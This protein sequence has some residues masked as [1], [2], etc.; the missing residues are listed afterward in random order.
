MRK[1]F[2][3]FLTFAFILSCGGGGGG[4]SP[5]EEAYTATDNKTSTIDIKANNWLFLVYMDADNNL[6]DFAD[7]DLQEMQQVKFPQ[8]V[9]VVVLVD[10]LG[11][12]SG[13]IYETDESGNL[14]LAESVSEPNMGD[15]QTLTDFVLKY[16]KQY[17]DHKKVL[18]F[19]NHGDGWRS[20]SL[21]SQLKMAAYDDTTKDALYMYEVKKALEDIT[22]AENFK[23]EVVGFD[24]CL[25]G[26]LEVFY[27]IANYTNYIV[28]SEQ[29]E[30]GAGWNYTAVFQNF[31]QNLSYYGDGFAFTKA[32]VDAYKDYGNQYDMDLTMLS[33]DSQSVKYL[34]E[35]VNK[36]AQRYLEDPTLKYEFQ[37]V[38]ESLP[39]ITYEGTD[40]QLVDLYNLAVQLNDTL[41]GN[42]TQ[43][44]IST[45][46]GLYRYTNNQDFQGISIYFPESADKADSNY[47]CSYY[48]PCEGGYYNPFT[49]TLWDEF[50]KAYLY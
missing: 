41:N 44:I 43:E 25:M 15:P 37:T 33:I 21:P 17:P 13:L 35:G 47:F 22:N 7:Q 49:G 29:F 19:W 5:V 9:K 1:V 36:I 40:Y 39:S 28:A 20:P 23:F 45:I 24:E 32:V 26:N 8:N 27:D 46:N 6:N 12:S 2:C 50:L 34:V 16:V 38:R 30:P 14:V 10:K 3:S 4:G 18:I 31:F 42:G 48:S 11:Y